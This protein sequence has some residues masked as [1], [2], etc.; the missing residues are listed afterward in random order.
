MNKSLLLKIITLISL[1]VFQ[2]AYA[3][4]GAQMDQGSILVNLNSANAGELS[5]RLFGV[6]LSKA[7]AIVAHREQ[8]G[9][10]ESVEDLIMVKG[11]GIKTLEENRPLLTIGE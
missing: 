11:I 9:D 10:F 4:D 7:D 8:H 3:D 1:A 5:S 2:P 6:G